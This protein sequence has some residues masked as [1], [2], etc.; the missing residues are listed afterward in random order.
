MQVVGLKL[1]KRI[2]S[3]VYALLFLTLLLMTSVLLENG[4]I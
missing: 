2:K 4:N 1:Q 3:Y